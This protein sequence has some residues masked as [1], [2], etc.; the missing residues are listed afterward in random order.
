MRGTLLELID[1]LDDA[2]DSDQY[3]PACL[4]AEGG[5]DAL[6]EARA[7]I[8]SGDDSLVCPQDNAMSYVLMLQLAKEAI[9]VWS[10]WRGNATPTSQDKFAAV[11][12]YS[13]HDAY[14][15]LDEG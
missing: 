2:D 7:M 14:L 8:C 12:F 13:R 1:R 6:P 10:D 9:V 5:P 11:M 15:P 4:F 3:N